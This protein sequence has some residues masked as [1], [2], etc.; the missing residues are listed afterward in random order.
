MFTS[1]TLPLRG[2][3][4]NPGLLDLVHAG[5]IVVPQF[6]RPWVWT[7]SR[8]L[9]LVKSIAQT[10]PAGGLL[11]M[12]G[13]RGFPSR[14]LD[15]VVTHPDEPVYSVLDG[16]QRLTALYLA[17]HGLAPRH[18][19]YVNLGEMADRGT[20]LEE[21]F[22][23]L[24]KRAWGDTYPTPGAPAEARVIPIHE[25]AN[26]ASWLAWLN[27]LP[28]GEQEK[29]IDVR[30]TQLAGLRSYQ[31]P[32]S[33][34]SKNA[35]LEILTNVFVTIN[36]QG[37]RLGAFDLM[38]AKSWLDPSEHPP[39]YDLRK[40]W[41]TA[42]GSEGSAATHQRLANF[43]IDGISALRLV[44]LLASPQG[45][46]S[47]AEI[48]RLDG[49][50][51]RSNFGVALN[52][53]EKALEILETDV[54]LIPES[55][56][57]EAG[58]IPI[59]YVLA[60]DPQVATDPERRERIARWFWASTFLQRYGKGGTNTII[61]P[62]AIAAFDWI[63]GSEDSPTW[64][65]NFWETFQKIDLLESQLTNESLLKGLLTLQSF[66]GARDWQSKEPIRT[67][68]RAPLSG[69]AK[70]VSRL[71]SHHVFPLD[72]EL[73]ETGG[74][75]EGGA[76]IPDDHDLV[77]NRVLLLGST[78][79]DLQ[80]TPPSALSGRGIDLDE[81]IGHLIDSTSLTGW[82]SFAK[83]RIELVLGKLEEVIP[84]P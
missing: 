59:A 55:T 70:P 23:A 52:A 51:V 79:S 73:P 30:E 43:R 24:T 19:L 54:A 72:N 22:D 32:V 74:A 62:D 21:D 39:G 50:S 17:I 15:Y 56:P 35:P 5:K 83:R 77:L 11:L 58:L 29:F 68:G 34:V 27:R 36:Q 7:H 80:A 40:I 69:S 28:K 45:S 10:W 46:V 44:K 26:E 4:D 2:P 71:E 37:V 84:R 12:E 31:F 57:P 65:Q 61:G 16:Q 81:L 6:Q 64:I 82:T 14:T 63:S 3:T 42:I 78:N 67:L 41:E 49:A 66:S 18:M 48:L 47:N 8:T 20:P 75:L 53:L 1:T 13:D 25:L 9:A 60:R 33:I 76:E 38:V